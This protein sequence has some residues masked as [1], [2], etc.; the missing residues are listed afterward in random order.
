MPYNLKKKFASK[1]CKKPA[2]EFSVFEILSLIENGESINNA[3]FLYD[4]LTYKLY[5]FEN[6]FFLIRIKFYRLFFFLPNIS[7]KIVKFVVR[8]KM[9]K[10]IT[11]NSDRYKRM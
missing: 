7:L 1:L 11:L 2:L 3:L 8:K 6:I 10:T 4:Q 5:Y 9:G